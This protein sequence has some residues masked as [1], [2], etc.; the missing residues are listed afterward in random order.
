MIM[1]GI[2]K[3]G[4]T[5]YAASAPGKK[6]DINLDPE[7]YLSISHV[8]N[9]EVWDYS[10]HSPAE[11]VNV[12]TSGALAKRIIDSDAQPG[13]T[14]LFDSITQ[15][16]QA[17]LLE[18]VRKQVGAGNKG[19]QP[20]IEEPGQ[21][22]YGARTQYLITTMGNILR[23]T[24]KKDC[25]CIFLAHEGT[26]EKNTKGEIL[27]YA[28][29]MSDNAINQASGAVSEIWRIT[30]NDNARTIQVRSSSMYRPCGTRMFRTNESRDFKLHYDPE[31][32]DLSQPMSIAALWKAYIDGG[33]QKLHIPEPPKNV[34]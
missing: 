24:R 19:F 21:T 1:W 15:L 22:A 23:A 28:P 20:T 6:W 3:S 31:K 4:K 34:R 27:Y 9:K 12:L 18:A 26:P 25:H 5:T 14:F 33:M 13:D 10:D 29:F 2:P 8:E 7:G 30:E 16:Q 32:D 17:G 11:L